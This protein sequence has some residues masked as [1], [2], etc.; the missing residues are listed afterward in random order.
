MPRRLAVLSY[1]NAS[2]PVTG[3]MRRINELLQAIGTERAEIIQPGDAHPQVPS[4]R[5]HPD[6]GRRRVGINWGMFNY[7]WPSTAVRV[8]HHVASLN[9]S[10]LVL[11]SIWAWAPF[12]RTGTRIPMVLDAQNVD[13]AALAERYG[14]EHPFTR[15]TTRWEQRVVRAAARIIACSEVD[16]QGFIEGYGADPSRVDVVPNGAT[17]PADRDLVEGLPLDPAIENRLRGA[18]VCLFI[19]GKLDYPP[20][21]EGLRFISET[22]LPAL[23]HRSPA[24]YKVLVVGAP[25]PARPLH[26]DIILVGRVPTLDPFLRRA[27]LC[28]APIFSGSGTRLKALDYLAWGKPVVATPKAVEGIECRNGKHALLAERDEF[29]AAV[30]RLRQDTAMARES[31]ANG[32]ELIRSR[33]EWTAVRSRW[34]ET[35]RPWMD[36]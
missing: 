6:F 24:R 30:E 16:R 20:N 22:L 33:Y 27:D 17:L 3:G 19:G 32:R 21:A 31:G 2:A 34:R 15:L 35:L 26:P 18:T 13:A 5:F 25:V 36:A 29:A 8:R 23:Q 1:Y 10:C 11:T 7:F 28:L 14:R 9:P 4:F 12:T